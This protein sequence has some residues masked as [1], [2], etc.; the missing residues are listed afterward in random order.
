MNNEKCCSCKTKA[1]YVIGILG[2]LLVVG[3]MVG[4][5]THST[6]PAALTA[7]RYS[8]RRKN[9]AE[10]QAANADTLRNGAVLDAGKKLVRVPIETAIKMIEQEW[11]DPKAGRSNLIARVEKATLAPPKA[12]EKKSEF[13]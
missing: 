13:E 2:S 10:L 12:P 11:Q 5:M 1:A 8:L 7:E 6:N 3:W 4:M 9:L